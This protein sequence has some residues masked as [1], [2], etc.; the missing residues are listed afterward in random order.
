MLGHKNKEKKKKL[1]N[2]NHIHQGCCFEIQAIFRQVIENK[3]QKFFKLFLL[4]VRRNDRMKT[5]SSRYVGCKPMGFFVFVFSL[6]KH[7]RER[8]KEGPNRLSEASH[9]HQATGRSLI[10]ILCTTCGGGV[11]V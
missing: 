6:Q 1:K 8:T 2:Y 11:F 9:Q 3:L 7:M 5:L 4:I 10:A